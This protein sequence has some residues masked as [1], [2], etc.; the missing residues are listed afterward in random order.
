M[1]PPL[2]RLLESIL[3]DCRD[4]HNSR[5]VITMAQSMGLFLTMAEGMGLYVFGA[6][7]D[8][9]LLSFYPVDRPLTNYFITQIIYPE[10]SDENNRMKTSHVTST[11]PSRRTPTTWDYT[12]KM[13]I[14]KLDQMG[15]DWASVECFQSV[16]ERAGVRC[17]EVTAV[18]TVYTL[19]M[20]NWAFLRLIYEI[21]AMT[22]A[23]VEIH[24]GKIVRR[25][26]VVVDTFTD[27][28]F[29]PPGSDVSFHYVVGEFSGGTVGGIIELVDG[30]GTCRKLCALT[31]R[32]YLP[33]ALPTPDAGV[34]LGML[35]A[36]IVNLGTDTD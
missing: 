8:D 22:E 34:G 9:F 23:R 27:Q 32:S 29:L 19:P 10:G 4:E 25:D 7:D 2:L 36:E 16:G 31:C 1:A 14:H 15:V 33:F 11:Q 35:C 30:N 21:H 12:A 20:I 13:I 28:T 26:G 5:E 3:I 17:T 24:L 6:V 18:I